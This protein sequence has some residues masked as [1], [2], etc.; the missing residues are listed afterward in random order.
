VEPQQGQGQ[1]PFLVGRLKED[2][3]LLAEVEAAERLGIS[4]KRFRGWEPK[5]TLRYTWDRD[6]QSESPDGYTSTVE[7]EWDE[8]EQGWMLALGRYRDGRCP[9][10]SGDL[11]DTTD[12]KNADNYRHE[13]ALECYR[14]RAF[15]QSHDAY[16]DQDSRS[17]LHVVPLRPRKR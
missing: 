1:Y 9:H 15:A 12:P 7:P 2:P 16:T 5:T 6:N 10:C 3:E 4:L 14:C 8:T 17:F 11:D 13:P